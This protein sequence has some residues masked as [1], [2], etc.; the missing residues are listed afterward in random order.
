MK[1]LIFILT[2]VYSEFVLAAE[3][4]PIKSDKLQIISNISKPSEMPVFEP[5][6]ALSTLPRFSIGVIFDIDDVQAIIINDMN[7]KNKKCGSKLEPELFFL[8]FDKTNTKQKKIN[9]RIRVPC[10]ADYK[11]ILELTVRTST[12]KVYFNTITLKSKYRDSTCCQ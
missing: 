11:A 3:I 9:T 7:I 2:L 8:S 10:V 12:K 4:T 1:I 5:N 6:D